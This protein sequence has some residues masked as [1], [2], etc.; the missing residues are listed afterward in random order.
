MQI[1][2]LTYLIIYVGAD[3]SKYGQQQQGMPDH[4]RWT[5]VYDG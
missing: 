2:S 3:S 1:N 4:R 5:A